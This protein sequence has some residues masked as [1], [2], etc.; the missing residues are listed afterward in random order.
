MNRSCYGATTGKSCEGSIV[1]SL[2]SVN[3]LY[4]FLKFEVYEKSAC[5]V[6]TSNG[7]GT[8]LLPS[9]GQEFIIGNERDLSIPNEDC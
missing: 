6:P 1:S 7:L 8:S 9:R 2:A 5:L 4:K 3:A